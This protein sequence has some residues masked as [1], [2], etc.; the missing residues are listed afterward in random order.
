MQRTVGE[1]QDEDTVITN[2]VDDIHEILDKTLAYDYIYAICWVKDRAEKEFN[3][4][5]STETAFNI[6]K[7]AMQRRAKN[8]AIVRKHRR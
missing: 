8:E 5:L 4:G 1:L 2:S 6:V 3:L 7:A